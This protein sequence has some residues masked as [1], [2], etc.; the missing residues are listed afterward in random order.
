MVTELEITVLPL[1]WAFGIYSAPA[2]KCSL[3]YKLLRGLGV[4]AS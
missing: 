4:S 3:S 1:E 2:F